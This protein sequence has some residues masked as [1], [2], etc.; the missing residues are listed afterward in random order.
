[1]ARTWIW[2]SNTSSR[3]R[4]DLFTEPP[5]SRG[6]TTGRAAQLLGHT[7]ARHL[8]A[9]ARRRALWCGCVRVPLNAL[10]RARKC[11]HAPCQFQKYDESDAGWLGEP[12]SGAGDSETGSAV[13]RQSWEARVGGPSKRQTML[14]S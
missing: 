3:L 1:M 12:G 11:Q 2:A 4:P 10:M 7:R 14:A 9:Q 8:W 13:L 6:G 5:L